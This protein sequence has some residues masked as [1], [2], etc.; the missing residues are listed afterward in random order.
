MA[1]I[2]ESIIARIVE[3]MRRARRLLFITGAGISADSGLPTYR[4]I[5]G[6]YNG[7][8]T[9]EDIP[10][11]TALS[12]QMLALDPAMTWK[13][14]AQIERACRGASYNDAHRIIAELQSHFDDVCVLTQN[15]DGF[16]RTAGSRNLIEIHGDIHD[17]S[18]TACDYRC[19][20]PDYATLEIPP[21][22]PRCGAFLRPDVV[23]FGEYLPT[24]AVE[25]LYAALERGFDMVF[26][27]GTTSVFPYI[28]APV[29]EAACQ[30][31]PTVEINPSETVVSH[32]VDFKLASGAA[33]SLKR[34]WKRYQ[35]AGLK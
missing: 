11:E 9:E 12:G 32:R 26:S 6:L 19:S 27:V 5:G 34:I 17:L 14:I 23:L 10:I 13:Y 25:R 24:D 35:N 29:T 1:D 31:I 2:D 33:A 15:V 7:R 16:H 22:C 3:R 30:G 21:P 4:G 18:C 28:A 8:L 20:V